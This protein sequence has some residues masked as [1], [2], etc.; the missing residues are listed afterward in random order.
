MAIYGGDGTEK[1][2]FARFLSNVLSG[3]V[4]NHDLVAVAGLL[5]E[6]GSN[7][8]KAISGQRRPSARLL[9]RI[10]SVRLSRE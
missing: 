1:S 8:A 6:D 10:G 3:E 9:T 2:G 5:E 4:K 7:L